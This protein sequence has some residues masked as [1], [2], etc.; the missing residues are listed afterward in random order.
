V[1]GNADEVE[2]CRCW[3]DREAYYIVILDFATDLVNRIDY[4]E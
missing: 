2:S 1:Y 4:H 3:L